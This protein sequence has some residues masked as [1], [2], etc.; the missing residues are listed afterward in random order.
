MEIELFEE[1]LNSL[2]RV[3]NLNFQIWDGNK[4]VFNSGGDRGEAPDLEA[5]RD[6]SARVMKQSTY[7]Q[8][9][10]Q[11]RYCMFGTPIRYGQETVGSLVAY[12][13][14]S[15]LEGN[16]AGEIPP[17]NTSHTTDME[18]FLGQL[19]WL[20]GGFE[21]RIG[22]THVHPADQLAGDPVIINDGQRVVH[23]LVLGRDIGCLAGLSRDLRGMAGPQAHFIESGWRHLLPLAGCP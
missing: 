15:G 4:L 8:E 3:S 18:S 20:I 5:Y 6:F 14:G 11:G 17:G 21:I 13:P 7:R 9:S 2:S 19:A 1:F 12:R 23:R 10:N 22:G 16:P